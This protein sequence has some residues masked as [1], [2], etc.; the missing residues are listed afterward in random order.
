[1][2]AFD[3]KAAILP[4]MAMP[5]QRYPIQDVLNGVVQ[6]NELVYLYRSADYTQC[7]LSCCV[8]AI[9][10]RITTVRAGADAGRC[11]DFRI[12]SSACRVAA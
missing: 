11:R 4:L 12:L 6:T 5:V 3:E 2:P 9:T 10:T 1:L 7:S 8:I